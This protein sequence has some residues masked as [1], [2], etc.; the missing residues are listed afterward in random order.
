[1]QNLFHRSS[2]SRVL[3]IGLIAIGAVFVIRLFWLQV[4]Q[5]DHYE[6]LAL[7]SQRTKF[8][9]PAKRGMIYARD[10]SR[11]VPLVM[12]EA[13]YLVYADP[14]EVKEEDK[15][16]IKRLM[17]RVAGGNTIK[18]YEAKLSDK[19]LRYTVMANQLNRRQ[20]ELIKKAQIAGIG[21]QESTKRVYPEKQLAGQL[22]GF[23]NA[24]GLGQYGVEGALDERLVGKDGVLNAVT[25]VRQIPL[26]ISQDNVRIPAKNGDNLVLNVDSNIQ[27]KVEEALQQGLK[28]VGATKGS[29]VVMDPSNGAVLSMANYPS[30]NPEEYTKVKDASLFNNGIVSEPYEAG[31]VIKTLTMGAG[32]DS[33]AVARTTTFQN[34][35]SVQVADFLIKNATTDSIGTTT[36][37]DVLHYSLNTGVVYILKQMGG[38]SI[39]DK[40]KKTLYEYFTERYRFDKKTG[41]EQQG[42]TTGYLV[43]PNDSEGGPVR[44]ANMSFGQ[45]MNVTMIEVASAFS[46]A[47]NGGTFYKPQLV[48]GTLDESG[49]IIKQDPVAL[50]HG[51]LNKTASQQLRDMVIDARQA[52]FLGKTD[53]KG[54]RVG[55]KTG[56]SQIIDKRT[57]KYIDANSIGT[58]LG[59][60]GDSTPRYV[61]MVKV[62]D[63]KTP[64][65]AGTVAAAPIFGEISNWLL[66]YLKVT[67]TR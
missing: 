38:G 27:R 15:E 16:D 21:L 13:V 22:L 24:E 35:G 5:H 51:V 10:G 67:P 58:Y 39:N 34:N 4:V 57:G 44:Y 56:T 63:S 46:A 54:Y 64:G 45:G 66:D 2:R 60:G 43:K 41:I 3:L 65:Y 6:A 61:I 55:G 47:I 12:N 33:G 48:G 30:Y 23:V 18:G 11:T 62:E 26:T 36:M 14:Q 1:M 40:A 37:T 19:S 49:K 50:Q 59:F 29:V 20:A 28:N 31:S 25:D 9:I 52:G 42:E 32:L 7:Q 17:R 8:T 53:K